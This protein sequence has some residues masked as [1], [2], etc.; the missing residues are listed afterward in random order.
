[1][2]LVMGAVRGGSILV[3]VCTNNA[4]REGTTAIVRKYRILLKRTKQARV[5]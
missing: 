5:G 2:E 4:D 1:M 3:H